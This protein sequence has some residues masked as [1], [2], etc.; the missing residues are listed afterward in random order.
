MC[1]YFIVTLDWIRKITNWIFGKH[2][3]RIIH[4][5]VRL[6][7]FMSGV[8]GLGVVCWHYFGLKIEGRQILFKTGTEMPSGLQQ[9][10]V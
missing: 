5:L 8:I 6:T 1:S 4:V 2:C 10:Q 7:L 3:G 9:T